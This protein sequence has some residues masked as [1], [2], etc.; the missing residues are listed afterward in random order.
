M[1]LEARSRGSQR[2]GK[3]RPRN[4]NEQPT[5]EHAPAPGGELRVPGEAGAEASTSPSGRG[6]EDK[7]RVVLRVPIP[8]NEV[9]APREVPEPG[10]RDGHTPSHSRAT[11]KAQRNEK[12][13]FLR[14]RAQLFLCVT[15]AEKMRNGEESDWLARATGRPWWWGDRL[16]SG[17]RSPCYPGQ[18]VHREAHSPPTP[19]PAF[20]QTFSGN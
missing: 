18:G 2:L 9:L 19:T 13:M 6:P 7:A 12:K 16:G 3:E 11:A 20:L 4:K 10:P 8:G 15:R 17:P 14:D 5:W 1:Q